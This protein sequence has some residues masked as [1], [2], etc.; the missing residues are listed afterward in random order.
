MTLRAPISEQKRLKLP[1]RSGIV[2]ARIA[3]PPLAQLGTLGYEAQ[4][5]EVHVGAAGDRYQR[6]SAHRVPLYPGLGPG[7]RQRPGRLQDRAGVLEHV[8]D[9]GADV[10]V[11]HHHHLIHQLPAQAKGLFAHLL[12]RHP[13]GEQPHLGQ[14][15]AVPC[16]ERLGHGIRV[17]R[18]DADDLDLWTQ[19]FDV[20]RDARN[21]ST[22][23]YRRKD[24]LDG[25]AAFAQDLHADGALAGDHVRVVV[26]VNE[27]QLFPPCQGHGVGVGVIVSIPCQD[28]P[29]ATGGHRG[30]LD[31]GS[32]SRHD[33][34][35]FTSKPLSGV[36]HTLGMVPG[37]GADDA[38]LEAGERKVRHLVVGAAQLE[39]T[40]AA[41][42]RA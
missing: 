4:A 24:R 10:V 2:T 17:Y 38:A 13:V 16:P 9:G 37:G 15:H 21:Q 28:N 18:L 22:A 27:G 42:P 25:S 19:P 14:P 34:G 23:A 40:P 39:R 12:Y 1:G 30:H 6:S 20:S 26:G 7:H 5:V 11:V 33:D 29:C 32:C 36:S 3:S 41:C 31:L 35:G 8:L